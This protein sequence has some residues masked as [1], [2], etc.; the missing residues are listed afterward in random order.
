[1]K[2]EFVKEG[3]YKGDGVEYWSI[4]AFKKEHGILPNDTAGNYEE[5]KRMRC[6]DRQW[7][8]FNRSNR[9]SEGWHYNLQYLIDFYR[10]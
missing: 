2:L 9:F 3:H 4:W 8:S 10:N 1:M 5:A 7:L 6:E